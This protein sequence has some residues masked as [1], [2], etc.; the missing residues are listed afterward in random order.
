[1]SGALEQG[2]RRHLTPE[3]LA[4]LAAARV[5]LA[6]AGGLG[7]NCA[8]MLARSGVANLV[9]VDGD[10]VDA[11]NLNRQQYFPRHV[12]QSKVCAL[13]EQIRELGVANID[14]RHVRF[15]VGNISDI[16]GLASVWVEALDDP[17]AKSLFVEEALRA[18]V[19]CVSASGIA[20]WGGPPMQRR[21]LTHMDGS[22]R[23]VLVGD[24]TSAVS[25]ALPPLAPRVIQA[26]A[27][28][29]DAV[30][31]YLLETPRKTP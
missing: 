6:G 27:M 3:Q 30:L 8:M 18:G 14:A 2:L 7:S 9:L 21:V 1:M 31:A 11:S 15:D 4:R 24:F 29:A 25:E 28:Q 20:G 16:L 13:S 10:V 23:L 22:L 5:G 17:E 26:A 12:G 19:F